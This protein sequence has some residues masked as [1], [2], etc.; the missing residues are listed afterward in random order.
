MHLSICYAHI[1]QTR[2]IATWL[3][4]ERNYVQGQLKIA[5]ACVMLLIALMLPKGLPKGNCNAN[6]TDF[7]ERAGNCIR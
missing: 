5:N 1:C 3:S 4:Q 6:L 2:R 7:A